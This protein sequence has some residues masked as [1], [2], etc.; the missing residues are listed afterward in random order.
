MSDSGWRSAESAERV[1]RRSLGVYYTPPV[2][3][4]F[5]V[6][7]G[8][9][10]NREVVLEPAAGNGEFLEAMNRTDRVLIP[11]ASVIAAEID[12]AVAAEMQKK[13]PA[14]TVIA[15]DFLALGREDVP[16]VDV[17][18]G[19]PPFI[20]YQALTDD[21]RTR[22]Q[23]LATAAGFELSRLAS[24]WAHFVIHATSF[25][26]EKHGR[27]AIVLP[28]ELLHTQ[29]G[30][31]VRGF[32]ERR[33]RSVTYL[34]ID[35]AVFGDAQVDTVLVLADQ[36]G[37][38][39]GHHARVSSV[40]TLDALDLGRHRRRLAPRSDKPALPDS[41]RS[42]YA[43]LLA[44]PDLAALG[45]MAEIDIGVVTG[46]SEFFVLTEESRRAHR[47][48]LPYVTPIVRRARDLGGLGV[49]SGE[50]QWLFSSVTR[51]DPAV[52]AYVALG[53]ADQVNE[54]YKCSIRTTWHAVPIPKARPDFLLPAMHHRSPRLVH[55]PDRL[56]ATN[57]MY[58]VDCGDG[59]VPGRWLA[60]ASLSTFTALSGEVEGRTYGGG[61]L[62]LEP[63]EAERLLIP[64]AT[65]A[66]RKRLSN[67]FPTLDGM[68]R[69]GKWAVARRQV[70]TILGVDPRAAERAAAELRDRR[71]GLRRR[72]GGTAVDATAVRATGRAATTPPRSRQP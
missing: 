33:F 28:A 5:L 13:Y 12:G 39:G 41:I 45:T 17:V 47:L 26:R 65:A 24:S 49:R 51:D 55:N 48:E 57:L 35:E 70:D 30:G 14:A 8:V 61:V 62:K 42:V 27:L 6:R 36:D 7:W 69:H 1:A 29:Y 54:G 23:R 66:Q 22:G 71:I 9:R 20:R 38:H 40:D 63:S 19:N 68:I 67:A 56:L 46:A 72:V 10:S 34:T 21:D 64:K 15:G 50:T 18:I 4:D 37:P 52:D 58:F 43:R 25:L 16:H 32:L 3:A 44:S 60:A 31:S 59:R 2:V 53:E 11:P